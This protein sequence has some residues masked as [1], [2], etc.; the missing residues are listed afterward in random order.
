MQWWPY[1]EVDFRLHIHF[2]RL[3]ISLSYQKETNLFLLT[4]Q[5]LCALNQSCPDVWF[6][7]L[8]V[9]CVT[10]TWS[11]DTCMETGK[12]LTEA[13][14]SAWQAELMLGLTAT[15]STSNGD[16][17]SARMCKWGGGN[18][19]GKYELLGF[20]FPQCKEQSCISCKIWWTT[21]LILNTDH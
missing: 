11:A 1:K 12:V 8:A 17:T 15:L 20:Y 2:F 14:L 16:D 9:N 19:P 18:M 10:A 6:H 7:W 21:L 3:D 4:T 13:M 5:K